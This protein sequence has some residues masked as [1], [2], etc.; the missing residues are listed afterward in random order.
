MT[1]RSRWS[2]ATTGGALLMAV[3]AGAGA[4]GGPSAWQYGVMIYGWLPSVS[5]NLN[6]SLPRDAGGGPVSVD[7]DKILD[8]LEF[9]FMAS[10]EARK[11]D[12]SVFTDVIYLD[13]DGD[14]SKSVTLPSGQTRTL[15]DGDLKLTGW[16]WTLGGGYTVWRSERSYLDLLAGARLLALDTDLGLTG[17]GL[18]ARQHQVSDSVDLWDGIVGATGRLALSDRWFVPYYADI[19]TGSSDSTWQVAGGVG[20]AFDWGEVMLLYRHLQ[21]DQGDDELLQDVSFGGGMLGVNFRF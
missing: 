5:G 4:A 1:T 8:A 6:Y 18:F 11:G 9:T 10:F 15:L 2:A 21:Y 7:A 3:A 17:A 14:D 12:W 16:V 19:G 13:L 20:Y